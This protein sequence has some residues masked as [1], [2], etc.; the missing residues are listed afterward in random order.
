LF[1]HDI[2]GTAD[3]PVDCTNKLREDSMSDALL[4]ATESSN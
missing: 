3:M 2:P 1:L 4:F